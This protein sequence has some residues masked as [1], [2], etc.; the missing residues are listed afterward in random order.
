MLVSDVITR[1]REI[2]NDPDGVRWKDDELFRWISDA[3]L[4]IVIYRPDATAET[5]TLTLVEGTRQSLPANSLRLLD[6][7]RALKTD[8]KPANVLRYIDRQLLDSQDANW[9][10]RTSTLT[11]KHVIYD[12]RVPT[13]FY[14]YPPAKVGARIDVSHSVQ[15]KD[16]KTLLD[17]LA[18]TDIYR[19]MVI[20]Y[21]VFRCYCKD[22]EARTDRAQ[23]F[24]SALS[25]GLGIKLQKDVAFSP[26]YNN[27]GGNPSQTA[28]SGGGV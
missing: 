23:L 13:E 24:L 20:N 6:V 9:H 14:V 11:P 2:V 28:I 19:E 21:V 22:T 26:D 4:F 27:R 5:T 16:V 17:Q 10:F 7:L 25:N 15:P 12:N 1:V 3:Q 8:G 18:I